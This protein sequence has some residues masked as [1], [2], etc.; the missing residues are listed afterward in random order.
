MVSG[1]HF[2]FWV[3]AFTLS[4]K[5]DNLNLTSGEEQIPIFRVDSVDA[6]SL[7]HASSLLLV[8]FK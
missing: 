1:V 7:G 8:S 3:R 5:N 2:S 4:R 6:H